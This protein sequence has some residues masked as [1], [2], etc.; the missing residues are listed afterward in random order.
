MVGARPVFDEF[1]E[2]S[3]C[4]VFD[5]VYGVIMVGARPVKIG[6]LARCQVEALPGSQMV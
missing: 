5:V 2:Y 4:C 3:H 6:I 1:D